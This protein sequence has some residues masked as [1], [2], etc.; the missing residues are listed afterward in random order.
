MLQVLDA[1]DSFSLARE[2]DEDGNLLSW[3]A[4]VIKEGGIKKD[5][6]DR[7]GLANS[8]RLFDIACILPPFLFQRLAD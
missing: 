2:E 6:E 1:G 5:D 7:S 4:L 8:E 3:K